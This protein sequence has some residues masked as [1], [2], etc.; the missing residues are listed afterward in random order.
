MAIS[1]TSTIKDSSKRDDGAD[2][3]IFY[4]FGSLTVKDAG[5]ERPWPIND[6]IATL[7]INGFDLSMV[8][9]Y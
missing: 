1:I 2:T 8:L 9:I 7:F 5:C 6:V 3:D 4:S